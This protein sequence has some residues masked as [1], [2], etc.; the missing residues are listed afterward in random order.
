MPPTRRISSCGSA[1]AAA[2]MSSRPT[3][4]FFRSGA[5]TQLIIAPAE[6]FE[7]LVDFADG[8]PVMLETGPDERNG[9][10]RP[11]APDG[12]PDYVP[13]MR[14]EPTM[15]VRSAAKELPTRLIEPAPVSPASAVQRRRLDS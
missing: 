4:V 10:F 2:F 13:V 1:T 9:S 3:G 14:F 12:S 5:V 11:L 15:T 8:K 6:R 7:V